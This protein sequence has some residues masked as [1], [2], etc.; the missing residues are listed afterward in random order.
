MVRLLIV[1]GLVGPRFQLGARGSITGT[2]G[3]MWA[4]SRDGW[5]GPSG[6]VLPRVGPAQC[7]PGLGLE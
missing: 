2:V 5:S 3:R 1:G 6:S 4:T 7:P